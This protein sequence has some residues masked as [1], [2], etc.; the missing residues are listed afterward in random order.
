[1]PRI[2]ELA[3]AIDPNVDGRDKPGHDEKTKEVDQ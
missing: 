3:H 1:V 2:Q